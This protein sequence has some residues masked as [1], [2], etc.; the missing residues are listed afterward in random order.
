VKNLII[1]GVRRL[2]LGIRLVSLRKKQGALKK[3]SGRSYSRERPVARHFVCQ[4]CS[5]PTATL[6]LLKI[7]QR[8][9]LFPG[10]N[11]RATGKNY[12][13]G[14]FLFEITLA[15]KQFT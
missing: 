8:K 6:K 10:R 4:F 15:Y 13:K 9:I 1:S 2:A 12:F 3:T 7:N 11:F 14:S 5:I